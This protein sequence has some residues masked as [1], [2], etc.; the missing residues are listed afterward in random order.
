MKN[1]TALPKVTYSWALLGAAIGA[2]LPF[3]LLGPELV[4]RL[5]HIAR[6]GRG[7]SANWGEPLFYIVLLALPLSAIGYVVGRAL[8]AARTPAGRSS[9]KRTPRP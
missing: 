7:E 6:G 1:R 9:S 2:C 3:L 8:E 5:S 4:H